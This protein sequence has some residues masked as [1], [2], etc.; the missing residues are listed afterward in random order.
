MTNVD[1]LL[2]KKKRFSFHDSLLFGRTV[3]IHGLLLITSHCHNLDYGKKGKI[4]VPQERKETEHSP[5]VYKI[6]GDTEK[7]EKVNVYFDLDTGCT[8]FQVSVIKLR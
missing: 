1:E 3:H 8:A 2:K 7:K 5:T 4:T 6:I